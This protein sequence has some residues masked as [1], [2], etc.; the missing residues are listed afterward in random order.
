MK[1]KSKKT[2]VMDLVKNEC[3]NYITGKNCIYT[4]K[5]CN[6]ES[7]ERCGYFEQCVLL[8]EKLDK[9]NGVGSTYRESYCKE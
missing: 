5:P 7:N 9:Y 2:L 8:L 6:L 4:G 1:K 3:A